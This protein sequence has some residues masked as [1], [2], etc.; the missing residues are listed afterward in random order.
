MLG[1]SREHSSP[2]PQRAVAVPR[3]LRIAA[4]IAGVQ[5]LVMVGLGV[6][7]LVSL[8]AARLEMGASTTFFFAAGGVGLLACAWALAR[9][10]TWGRGPV[11]LAQLVQLGLA[12][13]LRSSQFGWLAVLMALVA[14]V[15][16]VCL[17]QRQSIEALD[18]RDS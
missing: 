5:G 1:A 2:D 14:V 18:S 17:V 7:E 6:A 15:G 12:W 8:D 10:R 3:T 9:L 4:T 11:L 13:N 16:L